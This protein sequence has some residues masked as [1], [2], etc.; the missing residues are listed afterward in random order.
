MGLRLYKC[1]R[2]DSVDDSKDCVVIWAD[3]KPDAWEK[4]THILKH[5]DYEQDSLLDDSSINELINLAKNDY[6]LFAPLLNGNKDEFVR[7]MIK[8]SEKDDWAIEQ[9]LDVKPDSDVYV[10]YPKEF[11]AGQHDVFIVYLPKRYD[12]K[13]RTKEVLSEVAKELSYDPF[14]IEYASEYCVNSGLN[15]EFYVIDGHYS[16]CDENHEFLPAS[17]IMRKFNGDEKA[18][19]QYILEQWERNVDSFFSG[20]PKL[21]KQYKDYIRVQVPKHFKNIH[22]YIP[23]FENEFFYYVIKKLLLNNDRYNYMAYDIVKVEY[24]E[25]ADEA[26]KGKTA[27]QKQ[28]EDFDRFFAGVQRNIK[29][30]KI[31]PY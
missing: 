27:I 19:R 3:G 12:N 26:K 21:G 18:A 9:Q 23:P 1:Y 15:N 16:Y 7:L 29:S 4:L 28:F 6:L 24:P 30:G 11:V 20:N 10:A 31:T 8:T 25:D 14:L 22:E 5:Y 13:D 17:H 2:N